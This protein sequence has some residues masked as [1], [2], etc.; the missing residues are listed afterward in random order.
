MHGIIG[1]DVQQVEDLARTFGTAASRLESLAGELTSWMSSVG[2]DGG[3]ADRLRASWL[4]QQR[5]Q[6]ASAVDLLRSTALELQRQAD[7]QNQASAGAIPAMCTPVATGGQA[8]VADDSSWLGDALDWAGDALL[9]NDLP[10]LVSGLAGMSEGTSFIGM[11]S[12]AADKVLG[13]VGLALPA[14]STVNTALESGVSS[15][16]FAVEA[17]E[18]V[19]GYL[20]TAAGVAFAVTTGV[21]TG[22]AVVV[23]LPAAAS[24][25]A[26]GVG[27]FTGGQ[28]AEHTQIDEAAANV[29]LARA[30]RDVPPM[31]PDVDMSQMSPAERDAYMEKVRASQAATMEVTE[32]L[33]NPLYAAGAV[34]LGFADLT[35]PARSIF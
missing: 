9:I 26:W 32:N 27:W 22:A 13:P 8:P 35:A 11:F 19:G 12:E 7:Q 29:A 18:S 6:L 15:T 5:P 1:S 25:A 28:I 17:V 14:L 23:S 30:Y 3:D 4:D 21:A 31:P 2:W 24:G 33:Q 10:N 16:E 34:V 20:A